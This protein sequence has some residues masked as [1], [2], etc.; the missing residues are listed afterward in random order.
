MTRSPAQSES[1]CDCPAIIV[2]VVLLPSP[3][4]SNFS[5]EFL[6]VATFLYFYSANFATNVKSPVITLQVSKRD[7]FCC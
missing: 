1:A 4:Y 5:L 2:F 7:E 3:T 6:L